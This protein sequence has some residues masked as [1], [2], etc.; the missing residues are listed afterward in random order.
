LPAKKVFEKINS[1]GL[2]GKV[3]NDKYTL[4]PMT[5]SRNPNV[6]RIDIEIKYDGRELNSAEMRAEV[7]DVYGQLL[8]LCKPPVKE[9]KVIPKLSSEKTLKIEFGGRMHQ[10]QWGY[11]SSDLMDELVELS[12][13][14]NDYDFPGVING[15]ED[16]I[17]SSWFGVPDE[18]GTYLKEIK[19]EFPIIASWHDK[20]WGEIWED[21][22]IFR[23]LPVIDNDNALRITLEEEVLFQGTVGQLE[24]FKGDIH[25]NSEVLVLDEADDDEAKQ[26]IQFLKNIKLTSPY[27]LKIQDAFLGGIEKSKDGWRTNTYWIYDSHYK[28]ILE[29]TDFENRFCATVYG[30]YHLSS[31]QKVNDFGMDKI[32]WHWDSDLWE[33]GPSGDE[34]YCLSGVFY[35]DTGEIELITDDFNIKDVS[36]DFS[37]PTDD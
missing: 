37:W 28:Q 12:E 22:N 34:S 8:K 25:D 3:I 9:E 36:V 4:T 10:S 11:V 35:A 29:K 16:L 27:K 24:V 6:V 33:F 7:K 15:I 19:S 31:T 23:F 20:D 32:I 1:L 18:L 5:G 17:A 26:M 30:K 2:S 21:F 14:F 13:E